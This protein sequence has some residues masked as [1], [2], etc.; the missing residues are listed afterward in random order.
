MPPTGENE[1]TVATRVD[2]WYKR[3]ATACA[4]FLYPESRFRTP[5][6]GDE[7]PE[8]VARARLWHQDN[9]CPDELVDHDVTVIL[10]A[11]SEMATATVARFMELRETIKDHAAAL[12]ERR[13][14]R[15]QRWLAS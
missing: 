8:L 14:H 3:A 11:Y 2:Q 9:P 6:T 10:D 12:E 7:L 15:S 1:E 5:W 13:A 4:P